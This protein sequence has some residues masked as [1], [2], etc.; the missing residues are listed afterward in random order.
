MVFLFAVGDNGYRSQE[1]T[2]GIGRGE[3]KMDG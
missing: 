1:Q 2:T 3:I